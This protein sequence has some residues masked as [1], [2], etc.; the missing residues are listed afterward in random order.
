M[1]KEKLKEALKRKTNCSIQYD[2]WTCATCF[3]AISDELTNQDWQSLLLFRG[4]YTRKELDN[5]PE[6]I[7][8]TLQK[9]YDLCV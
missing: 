9:I 5:L 7:E 8:K 3:F 4:D 2:G 1:D 6:D